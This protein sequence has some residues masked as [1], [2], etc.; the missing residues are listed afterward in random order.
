MRRHLSLAAT[1]CALLLA[2][3][4]SLW[5]GTPRAQQAE[6]PPPGSA[7][8]AAGKAGKTGQQGKAGKLMMRG[9]A[10]TGTKAGGRGGKA[11]APRAGSGEGARFRPPAA[12][13]SEE[14]ALAAMV[15][16]GSL[17]AAMPKVR[18]RLQ[19]DPDNVDMHAALAILCVTAGEYSCALSSSRFARGSELFP[20]DFVLAEAEALRAD[21]QGR[22]AAVRRKE[23]LWAVDNLSEE[24]RQLALAAR[25]QREVGDLEGAA[26]DLERAT[27]ADPD[28]AAV[29]LERVLS[30]LQ[31]GELDEADWELWLRR[32]SGAPW[33][34]EDMEAE[35]RFGIAADDRWRLQS[36]PKPRARDLLGSVT[37]SATRARALIHTDDLNTAMAA[38]SRSTHR[39]WGE[40]LHPELALA[41]AAVYAA[42]DAPDEAEEHLRR[43]ALL[44]PRH[45]DWRT[46]GQQ[47]PR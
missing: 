47:P 31:Q 24:A 16:R 1:A 33:S 8:K 19:E 30:A 13:N 29:H 23:L 7:A 43:V 38:L 35:L 28:S 36:A 39:M 27:A 25:D 34:A 46:W 45:P 20:R 12:A 37:L 9:K 2:A 15:R 26:R 21:G 17:R 14:G 22:A 4:A 18:E 41:A 3:Q 6:A 42:A 32:R 44:A 40:V 11:K 10:G 5:P